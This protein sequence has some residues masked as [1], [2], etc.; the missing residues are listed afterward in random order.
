MDG[1]IAVVTGASGGIGQ[2]VCVGLHRQNVS[3]FAL[4]REF[5]EGSKMSEWCRPVLCDLI[6]P[7][8]I[9]TAFEKIRSE[10]DQIDYLVNIAGI[11]PKYTLEEGSAEH[12]QEVIDINLRGYYLVMR[13]AIDLLREGQGRS[14][15]N[16]SSIN[17]RL[18]IPRRSI[19]SASKAGI[20]GLTTGLARELGSEGIRINSVSPGWVFTKGQ[21][22][23]YFTQPDDRAKH[24][25]HLEEK[26]AI[27]RHI[28]PDDIANHI[29]FYLSE[30]SAA[31]TGHNCIVDAGWLLE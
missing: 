23:Q 17:F 25:A 12:W 16:V 9:E 15:V 2:A 30:A 19:Y 24:L 11:D 22:Q 31:S 13:E 8:A 18:G 5:D 26:Q 29:L 27:D 20:L 7:R 1:R 4:D 21:V 6:D 3:L 14:I 28:S 10:T